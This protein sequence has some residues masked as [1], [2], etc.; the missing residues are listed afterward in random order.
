MKELLDAL[1]DLFDVDNAARDSHA[2]D[3][4]LSY[5]ENPE[6]LSQL[7]GGHNRCRVVTDRQ[8]DGQNNTCLLYTSPSPRD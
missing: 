4:T 1:R 8:T 6:S 5:G 3:S 7:A 2:D